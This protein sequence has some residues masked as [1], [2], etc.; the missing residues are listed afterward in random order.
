MAHGRARGRLRPRHRGHGGA[1][2]RRRGHHRAG[3]L[4][5]AARRR[6]SRRVR[7]AGAV[8]TRASSSRACSAPPVPVAARARRRRSGPGS[9]W[10]RHGLRPRSAAAAAFRVCERAVGDPEVA[11]RGVDRHGGGRRLVERRGRRTSCARWTGSTRCRQR[12]STASWAEW[13]YFNGRS[14]DGSLRFYLTFLAGAP[15]PLGRRAV[16]VRLQLERAGTRRTIPRAPVDDADLLARAPDLDI[17]GNRVRL[18]VSLP[19]HPG[20]CQRGR[21]ARGPLDGEIPRRRSRTLAA[22]DRHPRRARLGVGLR[23]SG[24][25]RR[26]ARHADASAAR[27]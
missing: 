13:L 21:R 1:A 9:T 3:A 14:A 19:A 6:R 22:A 4:A 10:W 16:F 8:D 17:A 23:R 25:V 2:R 18:E 15:D 27:R 26:R 7:R 12:R 11:G 5:G 20:A 24:A